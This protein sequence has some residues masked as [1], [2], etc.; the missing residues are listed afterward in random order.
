MYKRDF[1]ILLLS[2]WTVFVSLRREGPITFQK[3]RMAWCPVGCRL[4]PVPLA[5]PTV[6]RSPSPTHILT[7]STVFQ[8]AWYL[9][10][11]PPK[12]DAAAVSN[13]IIPRPHSVDL[14]G[15]G[16]PEFITTTPGGD[17]L[18][19]AAPRKGGDGFQEALILAQIDIASLVGKNRRVISLAHGSLDPPM[20]DFVHSP[21]KQVV[22][23][24]CSDGQLML[25]DSNLKL[26]WK[27]SVPGIGNPVRPDGSGAD[28]SSEVEEGVDLRD[29]SLVI[30]PH[31]VN[32]REKGMVIV[33]FRKDTSRDDN[34]FD[35]YDDLE[36]DHDDEEEEREEKEE[37]RHE[38]GRAKGQSLEEVDGDPQTKYGTRHVSYYAFSGVNGNLVW[39]HRPE[40]FHKDPRNLVEHDVKTLYT[41]RL[42]T[43]L[44]SSTHYGEKSCKDYRESVLAS[45]PHGWFSDE[46]SSMGV[47]HFHKHR[48]HHGSQKHNLQQNQ[49]DNLITWQQKNGPKM[50]TASTAASTTASTTA[51]R[52]HHPNV[53]VSH[54]EDAMEVIHIFSG[55]P[56]CRIPLDKNV[57]HVDVNGDGVVDHVHA[58]G[59]TPK[60]TTAHAP[61]HEKIGA[62]MARVSSGI[63]AS[64][65]LFNGTICSA[66]AIKAGGPIDVAPPVT[67]AVPGKHGHYASR[68][69][70]KS[71]VFF[72]NSLGEV[73]AFD[74]RGDKLFT[75]HT[76]ITWKQRHPNYAHEVDDADDD[77]DD[78]DEK[79]I[80]ATPTFEAFP[81]RRHALPS[82]ILAAGSDTLTI[83]SEH[84]RELWTSGDFPHPPI[85]QLVV[86]DVNFDG[87][88]DLILVTDAG[89]F[90][91]TQY[92][93]PP[94]TGVSALAG[95]MLVVMLITLLVNA[96]E[97]VSHPRM[98]SLPGERPVGVS[99]RPPRRGYRGYRSTDRVD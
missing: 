24:L 54:T 57:L 98:D 18:I 22:A 38:Q 68:L 16:K 99:A 19:L 61:G 32:D 5:A 25:L 52:P 44:E 23:V 92:R 39:T 8:Q 70:Q 74:H 48:K 87:Y 17:K 12:Y 15:D 85:Q 41:D 86:L 66:A 73:T 79:P 63:P 29:V 13:G 75:E 49:D 82:G 67:L 97:D 59:G 45:L 77:D 71:Y 14:N 51:A 56:V 42:M 76:G 89:L 69:R 62:C 9:K 35:D 47:A 81:F 31:G 84:G 2:V 50:S 40:D 43:E 95:G 10:F 91:W 93:A 72:F 11:D 30:S 7:R 96:D 3:V 60:P 37:R 64:V 83:L 90:G 6:L 36:D 46:D 88:N 80:I 1:G 33:S 20:T 53:L 21:R 4:S 78:G 65:H 55:R 94:G 26:K 34:D 27:T 28:K 58:L